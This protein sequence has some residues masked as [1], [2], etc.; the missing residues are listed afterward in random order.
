MSSK[1][2]I[3]NKIRATGSIKQITKAMEM[4]AAAKMRKSE[5]TA[6]LARPYA[7]KALSLLRNIARFSSKERMR[8]PYFKETSGEKICLVA[9]TSDRGLCG[10][11]NSQVLKLCARFMQENKTVKVLDI[12]A[13]GKKSR[14]YFHRIGVIPKAEFLDFS[15]IATLYDVRP[16]TD[17]LIEKYQKK[18]YDRIIF[19]STI[20]I[21]AL[22][23]RAELSQALP[24][25]I[26][27]LKKIIDNIVP[28]YGKYSE[29]RGV[30]EEEAPAFYLFEPSSQIVFNQLVLDLIR[31]EVLH[32]IY[33][34]NASEHS[35]RMMA[36]KSATENAENLLE[37][38]GRQLNQIRQEEITNELIE[39][40][41]AK[42][43]LT[44]E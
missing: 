44:A 25:T 29:I 32:L 13:V 11:F 39:M 30:G 35:A 5:E 18:E 16:L 43:A 41:S 23:Q 8:S 7:K 22:K 38:L 26:K 9:V 42:E 2:Q 17:W 34:S 31:V 20:F 37:N 3:K 4:V 6:I 36:M 40:T 24:L 10:A 15:E 14:D 28:K 27:G 12:V 33:E 1:H 21:S 19:C